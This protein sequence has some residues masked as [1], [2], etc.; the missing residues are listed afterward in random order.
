M[1]PADRTSFGAYLAVSGLRFSPEEPLENILAKAQKILAEYDKVREFVPVPSQNQLRV[2]QADQAEQLRTLNEEIEELGD[3]L[4]QATVLEN[5]LAS[6]EAELQKSYETIEKALASIQELDLPVRQLQFRVNHEAILAKY[7]QILINQTACEEKIKQ[8]KLL[9]DTYAE[10]LELSP[11]ES[12][13]QVREEMRE[14]RKKR[15][16]LENIM[17]SCYGAFFF[18]LDEH[19]SIGAISQD[20]FYRP[21][22]PTSISIIVISD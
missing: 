3:E 15:Q 18:S 17:G 1:S 19:T 2:K 7:Q 11:P 8:L 10:I 5:S 21:T 14:L 16:P 4:K 12:I 9:I 6:E 13:Q 20:I 22:V